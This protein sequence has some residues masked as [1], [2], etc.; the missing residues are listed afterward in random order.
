M[1][2]RRWIVHREHFVHSWKTALRR[3][4]VAAYRRGTMDAGRCLDTYVNHG[5]PDILPREAVVF[6]ASIVA[7]ERAE[8]EWSALGLANDMASVETI[9]AGR[10]FFF[11]SR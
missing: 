3:E 6:L 2:S 5:E 8:V 10:E 1:I 7:A 9:E 11:P 4:L